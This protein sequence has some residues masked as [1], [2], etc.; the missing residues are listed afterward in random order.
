MTAED[1]DTKKGVNNTCVLGVN[2]RE[3]NLMVIL[4]FFLVLSVVFVFVLCL[5]SNVVC[6][7]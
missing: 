5:A 6:V 4:L 2:K 3:I 7:S 1:G